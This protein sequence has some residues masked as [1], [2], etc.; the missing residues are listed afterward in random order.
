[1]LGEGAIKISGARDATRSTELILLGKARSD[2]TDKL[3]AKL[4]AT[5]PDHFVLTFPDNAVAGQQQHELVG[6]V[7]SGNMKPRAAV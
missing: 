7:K 4:T 1:M 5:A 6:D 2:D 3:G